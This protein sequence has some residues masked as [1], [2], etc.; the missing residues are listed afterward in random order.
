MFHDFFQ[1]TR[2]FENAQL[3]LCARAFT[4]NS[5]NGFQRV[6]ASQVAGN[7]IREFQKFLT[8]FLHGHFGLFAEIDEFA[9]HSPASGTPFIF[10]D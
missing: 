1:I 3:S 6:A 5:L 8:Q 2:F 9:F 10:L 4:Q 7:I